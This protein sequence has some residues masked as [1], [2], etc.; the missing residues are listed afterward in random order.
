MLRE[1]RFT[2]GSHFYADSNR[3]TRDV[4][5]NADSK[6]FY[7]WFTS[8]CRQQNV[9][10]VVHIFME[11]A[12]RSTRGLHFYGD[13]KTFYPWF[14]FLCRQQNVSPVVH[15]FMRTAKRFTH[16]SHF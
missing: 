2:R 16:G 14:T 11:T 1:K 8:L 13:S 12:K 10:P 9:L 4:S 15:I 7:T 6:T 3:S 5:F